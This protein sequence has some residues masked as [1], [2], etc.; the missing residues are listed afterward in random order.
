MIMLTLYNIQGTVKWKK[1]K[2][3][4]DNIKQWPG[5]DFASSN[6]RAAEDR[7]RWKVVFGKSSV[8]PQQSCKVMGRLYYTRLLIMFETYAI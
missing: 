8:V 3:W 1:E 2:R 7:A 6:I 5:V 4:E